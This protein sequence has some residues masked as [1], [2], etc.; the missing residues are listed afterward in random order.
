M[1]TLAV[2]PARG[3]SKG[4]PHKNIRTLGTR[5]LLAYAIQAARGSTRIQRTVV[6]T[7]EP[8]I[9]RLALRY[10]AEVIPRPE[11]ISGDEASS[12]SALRHALAFLKQSQHYQPDLLVFLQCTAPLTCPEDIDGTILTLLRT[13][14]DSALAV[15]PCHQFLW[16]QDDRGAAVG[17]NHDPRVRLRRQERTPQYQETGAVY[18]MRVPGFLAAGHRFFGK[19]V[20]HVTPRERCLEIDEPADL[21]LAE[22]L[23]KGR[24]PEK[25]SGPEDSGI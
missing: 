6:S 16:K 13:G 24:S 19:T 5:P 22:T 3:G 21:L 17:I 7:D 12:E 8:E 14:A 23:L 11:E 9:A 25:P 20:F 10:G 2:I 18:V 15:A 4:I 1:K